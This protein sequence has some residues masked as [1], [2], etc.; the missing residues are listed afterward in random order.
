[1]KSFPLCG[2]GICFCM[3]CIVLH[4]YINVSLILY[5]KSTYSVLLFDGFNE[6]SYVTTSRHTFSHIIDSVYK[7]CKLYKF[8]CWRICLQSVCSLSLNL[9]LSLSLPPSLSL[10]LSLSLSHTHTPTSLPP[11]V[12]TSLPPSLSLSLSFFLSLS[13][14]LSLT[15]HTHTYTSSMFT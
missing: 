5:A 8:N 6:K 10:S 11:Y 1:M 7:V 15:H 14:S 2:P 9:S 4:P 12:P 3:Y 13:I